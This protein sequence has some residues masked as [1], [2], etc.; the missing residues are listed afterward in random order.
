MGMGVWMEIRVLDKMGAGVDF[1][2]LQVCKFIFS[3]K[4]EWKCYLM[5]TGMKMVMSMGMGMGMGM[6]IVKLMPIDI[7][8]FFFQILLLSPPLEN[9]ALQVIF[10]TRLL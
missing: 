1:E 9:C 6:G 3:C 4:S 7:Q 8:N 5:G 2:A 10:S